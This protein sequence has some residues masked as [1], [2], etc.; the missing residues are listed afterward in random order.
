MISLL[1]GIMAGLGAAM[2]TAIN[3]RLRAHLD[4]PFLTAFVSFL[5]G[6]LTIILIALLSGDMLSFLSSDFEVIPWWTWVG[7]LLGMVSLSTVVLIFPK[8]GAVQTAVMPIV[9]QIVMGVLIDT[10]GWLNAKQIALSSSRIVGVGLVL[11]GVFVAV[12]LPNLKTLK[13]Q[14]AGATL[15][16]WRGVGVL[17]GMCAAT[18]TAVNGELGRLL[19]SPINATVV[20]FLGG[21]LGLVVV[22]LLIEKSFA[23]LTTPMQGKPIWIWF[24]GVLSALFIYTSIWLVPQIGTGQVVIL[25]LIGS[26]C[27]SLLVDQF[28]LFGVARK[29]VALMQVLG[30]VLLLIGVGCVR[31]G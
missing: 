22:V 13:A 5:A 10:F 1:I 8:L 30:V 18:Q 15:W 31:L 14:K 4:V 28:G 16:L 29:P 20:S 23:R 2:M 24:G 27:G 12:V 3:D 19:S 17:G 11:L 7:G 26:I 25:M 9:G 21:T 6:L